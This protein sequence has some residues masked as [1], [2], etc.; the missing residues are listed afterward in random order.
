MCSYPSKL[1]NES[2]LVT[3][4]AVC[5]FTLPSTMSSSIKPNNLTYYVYYVQTVVLSILIL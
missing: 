5:F 4:A 2:I 1:N 3:Y